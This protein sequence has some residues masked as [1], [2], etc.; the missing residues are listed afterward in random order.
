MYFAGID[1]GAV[2]TKMV[3]IDENYNTVAYHI[4]PTGI[5]SRL[6]VVELLNKCLAKAGIKQEEIKFIIA[7]GYGRFN[8]PFANKQ[9][10]EITCHARGAIH[11][12]PDTRTVIDIGGQDSKAIR[13]NE[14]GEVVDFAMND[15]C[16]AGTGRFLEKMA[17]VLEVKI[18]N[19]G[20]LSL[21]SKKPIE[22]SSMC[23]VF[24][25]S[26]VVSLL[27]EGVPREDIAMALHNAVADRVI[28][29]ARKVKLIETITL[30]G[31]VINNVG[32]VHSLKIKLAT[33]VNLS[34]Q[35]QIIGAIG[36]AVIAA[37]NFK[38]QL[39]INKE[40]KN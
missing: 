37:D 33:N 27:A 10:S 24:A 17:D 28:S 25:E 6:G 11:L 8:V 13:I 22:I 14:K 29:L 1:L 18:K 19:L 21:K 31:G 20:E 3:L 39:P 40:S 16:A 38:K 4:M 32:I 15:K 35:P 26:E 2:S 34:E 7:T 23:A 30:T 9:I 36:A 12:F 5:K